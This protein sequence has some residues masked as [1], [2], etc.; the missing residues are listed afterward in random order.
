MTDYGFVKNRPPRVWHST[1]SSLQGEK[2]QS[3]VFDSGPSHMSG[4]VYP[5]VLPG[6]QMVPSPTMLQAAHPLSRTALDTIELHRS[7]IRS[8]FTSTR[9]R[10]LLVVVGPCSLDDAVLANGEYAVLEF[11]KRLLEFSQLPEIQSR[12]QIVMRCPPAKPRT[13]LGKRGLEQ[14]QLEMAYSLLVALAETGIP[15]TMEF[16]HELHFRRYAHLM[17]FGWVGARNVEDTFLRHLA[18][19]YDG[20]AMYFKNANRPRLDEAINACRT[21]SERHWVEVT[22]EYGVL[23]SRLSSGNPHTGVIFRGWEGITPD[24]FENAVWGATDPIVVDL[25]HTNARAFSSE[26]AG[27]LSALERLHD[28]VKTGLFVDGIMLES[29][30]LE[31]CD[32]SGESPGKSRTDPCLSWKQTEQALRE[33]ALLVPTA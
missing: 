23:H 21:A 4:I 32:S 1:G 33:L 31:G 10:R 14:M 8:R 11:A 5:T 22:D 17:T 20:L 12:L 18:S 26:A 19:F 13:A 9:D 29:Y 6:S 30:L 15:L 7:A 2:M 3:S 25:S 16:M 28:L 24:E 27:Q